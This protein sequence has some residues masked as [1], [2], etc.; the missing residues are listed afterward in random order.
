ML[1][2]IGSQSVEANHIA[3]SLVHATEPPVDHVDNMSFAFPHNILVF[4]HNVKT[5]IYSRF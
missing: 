2:I 4:P 1:E 3:V 5:F